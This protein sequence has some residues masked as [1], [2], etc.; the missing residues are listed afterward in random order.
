MIKTKRAAKKEA[1]EK[2]L[3]LAGSFR[4]SAETLRRQVE[5]KRH[6]AI[7]NQNLTARRAMIA[8]GMRRDA[9]HLEEIAQV[10]EGMAKDL[11]KNKLP[12]VLRGI[13][14]RT[15]IEYML[16]DTHLAPGMHKSHVKEMLLKCKF[17]RDAAVRKA[18]NSV[19]R[20]LAA[21]SHEWHLELHNLRQI[22]A[23]LV[24]ARATDRYIGG[25]NSSRKLMLAGIK[26]EEHWRVA[27]DTVML[28]VRGPSPEQEKQM[29]LRAME[30]DLIGRKIPGFFPTPKRMAA[31]LVALA[32]IR[33][34]MAVL[35]PSAGKGDIAEVIAEQHPDAALTVVERNQ[36]L[37]SILEAKG[38]AT[39]WEDFLEQAGSYDRIVMNPPFEKG[40]DIDH[41][42]HAFARLKH[43]GVVVSIVC[44]GPFYRQDKKATE[45]REWVERLGG[46]SIPMEVGS[47][48]GAEAFVQTGVNTRIL[49][50]RKNGKR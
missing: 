32:D 6:P 33:A 21:D 44:E 43:G 7:A 15:L 24:L 10:M 26:T 49:V 8:E 12:R 3:K 22:D 1:E 17:S 36:T 23:M 14:T 11:E 48:T 50:L 28:Y 13:T 25:L 5:E 9:E 39:K 20:L 4:K 45:F 40:Q 46:S 37:A 47:F 38:F 18:R 19:K 34:G 27:H 30:F 2:R 35:E 16:Y 29:K 31:Q 42:R 41:I